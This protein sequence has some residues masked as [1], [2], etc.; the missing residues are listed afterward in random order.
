MEKT[1]IKLSYRKIFLAGL[2]IGLFPFF[3]FAASLTFSPS[4]GTYS[5]GSPI[6]VDVYVSSTDE[7]MNAVSGSVS[8]SPKNFSVSYISKVGSI[9]SLWTADPT[10]SNS[11]GSV[12][13]EGIVLNPGFMGSNGKILS[14]TFIPKV[15]GKADISFD[16]G[17]VLA[18]DGTGTSLPLS[19]GKGQ[20]IITKAV[21]Q[22]TATTTATTTA[23]V[24]VAQSIAS[25][26][27]SACATTTS[28]FLMTIGGFNF[29]I[30]LVFA[31]VCLLLIVLFFFIGRMTV[32][33][34]K[35]KNEMAQMILHINRVANTKFNYFNDYVNAQLDVLEK[36]KKLKKMPGSIEVIENVR[37]HIADFK[38]FIEKKK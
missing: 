10:F 31:I 14:I 23:I 24:P 7:S 4:S 5:A 18:N 37:K 32:K 2:I 29:N 11:D 35:T 13:F 25:S 8:F 12:N 34:Y 22:T 3:A 6:T 16:S 28:P 33:R 9:I 17:S 21:A 27:P 38:D 15:P 20:F 26:S 30:F 1:Q 36:D 19:L